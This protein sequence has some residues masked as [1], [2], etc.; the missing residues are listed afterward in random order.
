MSTTN[1]PLL[2]SQR[3]ERRGGL[4]LSI[5]V[6]IHTFFHIKQKIDGE[7]FKVFKGRY[8]LDVISREG[9]DKRRLIKKITALFEAGPGW[10]TRWAAHAPALG[11]YNFCELLIMSS[12]KITQIA[13]RIKCGSIQG[14]LCGLYCATPPEWLHQAE[15]HLYFVTRTDDQGLWEG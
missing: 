8:Q 2:L 6:W 10:A 9:L 4:I 7:G 5:Y 1:T 14:W 15:G 12:D 11:G 3:R 13:Y